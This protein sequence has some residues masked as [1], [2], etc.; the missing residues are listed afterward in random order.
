MDA[1]MKNMDPLAKP[2]CTHCSVLRVADDAKPSPMHATA[3][4]AQPTSHPH[5]AT[6]VQPE[7]ICNHGV[8]KPTAPGTVLASDSRRIAAASDLVGRLLASRRGVS[9]AAFS[10]SS[11]E[12]EEEEEEEQEEEDA[13][14]ACATSSSNMIDAS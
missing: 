13:L 5:W 9:P 14:V 4:A 6:A 1:T 8:K 3:K 2:C 12:E 10:T 7:Q 11:S